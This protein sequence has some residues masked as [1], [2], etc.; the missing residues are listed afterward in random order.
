MKQKCTLLFTLALAI[1]RLAQADQPADS[2][3]DKSLGVTEVKITSFTDWAA[4]LHEYTGK[5]VVLPEGVAAALSK[6][7]A[8]DA[9]FGTPLYY[10]DK[11]GR[12]I[13]QPLKLSYFLNCFRT[14]IG[15]NLRYDTGKDAF[16][17]NFPWETNDD[18]PNA[19]LIKVL[20]QTKPPEL[21]PDYRMASKP[22]PWR[23]AFDGLIGKPENRPTAW[24][25]RWVGERMQPWGYLG[26][27]DNL[28]TGQM[29]DEA[30]QPHFVILNDLLSNMSPGTD[31]MAYYFFDHTGK[32]EAA[33]IV[34]MGGTNM[35]PPP[36]EP[37]FVI[38][39]A[40]TRITYL[41]IEFKIEK[42]RLV[43]ANNPPDGS[44]H[45]VGETEF[46]LDAPAPPH[47]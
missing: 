38:N 18:R 17:L 45:D 37:F 40:H 5:T 47:E 42:S 8:T 14:N 44:D 7:P 31:H 24:V 15:L 16:I 23:K 13:S 33:G 32:I 27:A 10:L 39:D 6:A 34:N 41:G 26:P 21:T 11:S 25:V 22:D 35:Q 12:K 30:G 29:L 43:L 3:P 28:F 9:M 1:A 4:K 19:E 2:Y 46:A 36:K 20:N